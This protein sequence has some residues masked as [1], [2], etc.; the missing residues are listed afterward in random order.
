MIAG[1][2]DRQH[3]VDGR[4]SA[5]K[6]DPVSR[7]LERSQIVFERAPRRMIGARVAVTLVQS[8]LD[9]P[10]CR[11]LINRKGDGAGG[12]VIGLAGVNGECVETIR[13]ERMTPAG[14]PM[15]DRRG[16]LSSTGKFSVQ[17]I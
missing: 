9:L 13:H 2:E 4:H 12:V 6:R 16:R 10:E 14:C 3:A 5:G 8:R 11:C 15:D 7:A 17:R 1:A